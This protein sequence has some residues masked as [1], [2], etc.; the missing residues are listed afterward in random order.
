MQILENTLNLDLLMDRCQMPKLFEQ[1]QLVNSVHGLGKSYPITQD[2]RLSCNMSQPLNNAALWF[3]FIDYVRFVLVFELSVGVLLLARSALWSSTTL[4][5]TSLG[6][7]QVVARDP[8]FIVR[9]DAGAACWAV[10]FSVVCT[11]V[12]FLRSRGCTTAC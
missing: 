3:G 1:C 2:G 9:F 8:F 7:L 5:S 11:C 4:E 12:N 10:I 6:T